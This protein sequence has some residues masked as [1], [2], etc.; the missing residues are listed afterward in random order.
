MPKTK[1]NPPSKKEP[2][3]IKFSGIQSGYLN[4]VLRRQRREFN[5]AVELVYAELGITEKILQAPLGKYKLRQDCSGLDVLLI[6]LGEKD[7]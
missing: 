2:G 4:E 1:H 5:E 6:K 7:N 3:F